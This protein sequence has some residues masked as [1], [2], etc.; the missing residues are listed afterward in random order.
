MPRDLPSADEIALVGLPGRR[1]MRSSAFAKALGISPRTVRR[2]FARGA[3]PGALE[4]GKHTLIV[5]VHL[6]RLASTYGL[7]RVEFMAQ[8]GMLSANP[9]HSVVEILGRL[10][11]TKS[12]R[13]KPKPRE[14]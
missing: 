4:H 2:A 13:K 1:M 12:G 6:L 7:R 11:T 8:A 14:G 5:P 3:L 9:R 10:R